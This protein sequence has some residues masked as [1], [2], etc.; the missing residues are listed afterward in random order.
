MD[1]VASEANVTRFDAK[2]IVKVDTVVEPIITRR[3]RVLQKQT[4]RT[5]ASLVEVL[6]I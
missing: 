6:S 4:T 3:L 2:R 5:D 1:R